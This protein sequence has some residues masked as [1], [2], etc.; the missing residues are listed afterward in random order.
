MTSGNTFLIGSS[1]SEEQRGKAINQ[2]R[3]GAFDYHH[4]VR[5]FLYHIGVANV[6]DMFKKVNDEGV[7]VVCS[8][9]VRSASQEFLD[10]WLQLIQDLSSCK[11]I[12]V[13]TTMLGRVRVMND[14]S[15]LDDPWI[16]SDF[17]RS[18]TVMCALAGR[19]A[20]EIINEMLK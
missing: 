20:K 3:L 5:N 18:V 17:K 8:D 13:D 6:D 2:M 14:R 10:Q 12:T 7:Q 16:M 4:P 19:N 11:E 15:R 1:L 9:D